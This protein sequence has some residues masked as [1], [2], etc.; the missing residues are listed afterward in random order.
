MFHWNKLSD[1][2]NGEN[3]SDISIQSTSDK[4]KQNIFLSL[5]FS[6]F[7]QDNSSSMPMLCQQIIHLHHYNDTH[8]QSKLLQFE[9]YFPP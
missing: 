2:E 1:K 6:I 8:I 5:P 4:S 3:K 7:N 9:H